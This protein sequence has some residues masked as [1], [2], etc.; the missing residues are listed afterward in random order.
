MAWSWGDFFGGAAGGVLQ[1]VGTIFQA[2]SAEDIASENRA[3][4]EAKEDRD[5]A[6]QKELM[7]LGKEGKFLGFTGPQKVQVLQNQNAEDLAAIKTI[8][9]A[10]QKALL[11]GR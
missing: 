10:Y 8:V 3:Y 11:G 1:T 2:N 6:R 7:E 5:F 4:N 9:D